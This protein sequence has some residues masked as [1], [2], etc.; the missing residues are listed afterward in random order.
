VLH[1]LA[2]VAATAAHSQLRVELFEGAWTLAAQLGQGNRPKCR[3]DETVDQQAVAVRLL[4]LMPGQPL[5][6]QVAECD[7]RPGC[8]VVS[9]LLAQLVADHDRRVLGVGRAT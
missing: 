9:H 8:R 4:D 1:K 7:I 2:A 6:E 5:I 3:T